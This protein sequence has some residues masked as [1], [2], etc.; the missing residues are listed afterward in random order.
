[1][2]KKKKKFKYEGPFAG[3]TR[4]QKESEAFKKLSIHAKWLYVEY[5]FKYN[6]ENDHNIVMTYQEAKEIMAIETF[7]KARNKL[8]ER[9]FIDVIRRG[10]LE[11]Q[12]TIYGLSDRWKKFGTKDFIRVNLKKILPRIFTQRF[13]RG[14]E[15]MGNRFKKKEHL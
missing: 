15:F 2:V 1:M 5:R 7:I 10:G 11:K 13:K 14:H 6:G 4:K 8:I 12:P 9:G 3:V